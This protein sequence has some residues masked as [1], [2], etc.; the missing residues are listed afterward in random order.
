MARPTEAAALCRLEAA[1]FPPLTRDKDSIIRNSLHS[2]WQEVWIA[3]ADGEVEGALFLR[4]F[5]RT[6]RIHSIAVRPGLQGRGIGAALLRHAEE[7][8]GVHRVDHIHLEAMAANEVLVNWYQHHG[9]IKLKR[10]PG[11][12]APGIDAWRMGKAVPPNPHPQPG[13]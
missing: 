4:L 9:Y 8:A 2:P 10:L 7:R 5:K 3:G 1:C 13:A 11:Y 6:L 12:Y